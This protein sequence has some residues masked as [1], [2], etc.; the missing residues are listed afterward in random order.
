MKYIIKLFPEITIKSRPVRKQLIKQLKANLRNV[1][2]RI[3]PKLTVT[4]Q[5]DSVE[6]ETASEDSVIVDQ[7]TEALGH[8]PGIAYFL[9][10]QKY[11]YESFDD[12]LE[13]AKALYGHEIEGKTLCVRVKRAGKHDFKSIDA[14]RY[15]GGGLR[16]HCNA[17]GID[18]K[19][20]EI[21]INMEIRDQWLYLV[22]QKH[23][24]LGGFPLGSQESVLSL[25][26]GGFDSTVASY[27]TMRRGIKTH[28]CFF[29]LGGKAHELGVKEVSHYIWEKFGSSHGVKFV[30]VPF[31]GVVAEIL[32]KVDNS[33]MGVVLKRMMYRAASAVAEKMELD[34]IVTGESVA[35]VSSQT[36]KNLSV[37]DRVTDTLV[38]RPLVT[39]HKQEIVDIATEIGTYEFAANMPEY[40]GVISDK[41]TTKA[42]MKRVLEVE[43]K[44]DFAVLE[45]ALESLVIQHI[46]N[47]VEDF[48]Q[49]VKVEE[50]TEISGE[51]VVIDIRHP[52]EEEK[53]P[54]I[55]DDQTTDGMTVEKIPFY[56]LHSAFKEMSLTTEY[57]LYCDRGVMSQLHAQ[58]LQADGYTNVKVFK[59]NN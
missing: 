32:E 3:D 54:L 6:V 49:D 8:I 23:P 27:L 44:F 55:L 22:H 5:W 59:K 37:I 9:S 20:P 14:E 7:V 48:Q 34:T 35:Q 24:G 41:P 51:T 25:M 43:E 40:C 1:L 13:K 50:V 46:K 30:S 11:P 15:L 17:R 10:V 16:Q 42:S 53:S 52:D 38:L 19:N 45:Q 39:T 33:Y 36:L 28:F 18:L 57:L 2:K 12:T 29:N 31:E 47:V 21:Q 56:R 58:Q 4:G 26:S